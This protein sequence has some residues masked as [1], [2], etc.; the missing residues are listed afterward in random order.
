MTGRIAT[1]VGFRV[2]SAVVVGLSGGCH[3]EHPA[4]FDHRW[5]I[6]IYGGPSP[7]RLSSPPTIVNPVI[8][9][10]AVTDVKARYV[11]DPF[12]VYHDSTWYMFFEVMR[13]APGVGADIGLATSPDGLHWKYERLV[14][15]EKYQLGYPYVFEWSGE[16]Y[17]TPDAHGSGAVR[18]Y[19]ATRFPTDWVFVRNLFPGMY[20]DPSLA[21]YEG[22]W[23][24][25]VCGDSRGGHYDDMLQ[26]YYADSLF[27]QWHPHSMNPI[28]TDKSQARPG[29]RLLV[30][31]DGTGDGPTSVA[32]PVPGAAP[33]LGQPTPVLGSGR[34][35][36]G[37]KAGASRERLYRLTQAC[38]P[39]YGNR[40]RV[41]EIT[42]LSPTYYEEREI[43][44]SPIVRSS[45]KN[46]TWNMWG[47]HTVDPHPISANRW[48]A[49][50]DGDA[51]TSAGSIAT[52]A[53]LIRQVMK[54]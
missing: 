35:R 12:M 42:R 14:L 4:V 18:L 37:G 49:C 17:M 28:S 10:R 38:R 31:G 8:T 44:E 1:A 23:W 2:M 16:F 43:S 15:D 39:G 5:S 3:W 45:G 24:A 33:R 48:I 52:V 40:V 46:N 19:K 13:D 26:V 6:A 50:V 32:R 27:G 25:F 54:Q 20:A 30:C 9:A 51:V 29:G 47:M 11:A 36:L 34:A 22:K 53:L 21:Y 41:F 7:F